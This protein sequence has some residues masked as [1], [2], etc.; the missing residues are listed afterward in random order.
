MR[1]HQNRKNLVLKGPKANKV[2]YAV[3]ITQKFIGKPF[4]AYS[5]P[6]HLFFCVGD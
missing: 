2:V 1:G 6:D 4:M 5:E 3:L